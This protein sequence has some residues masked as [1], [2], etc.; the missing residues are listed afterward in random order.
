MTPAL[1]FGSFFIDWMKNKYTSIENIK[2]VEVVQSPSSFNMRTDVYILNSQ[3]EQ[4]LNK[5]QEKGY[6]SFR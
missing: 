4:I 2:G 3:K 1:E 5:L 6:I